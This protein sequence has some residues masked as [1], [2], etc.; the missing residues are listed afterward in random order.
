MTSLVHQSLRSDQ[1]IGAGYEP[2]M[3]NKRP[4]PSYGVG[5]RNWRESPLVAYTFL[6]ILLVA[7]L[8]IPLVRL[9]TDES[10]RFSWQMFSHT[11][12]TTDFTVHTATGEETVSLADLMA[13][14]RTD[15]PLTD[16]VPLHLCESVSSA[17]SVSW[18]SGEYTC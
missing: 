10:T 8:T 11:S 2:T 5:M 12:S 6:S 15:L 14:P 16:I 9:G 3:T 18:D 7:M 13:R 4:A 1:D 17:I